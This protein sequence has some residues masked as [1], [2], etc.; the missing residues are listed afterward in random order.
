MPISFLVVHNVAPELTRPTNFLVA[1]ALFLFAEELVNL[2]HHV[3]VSVV[4]G[5][6]PVWKQYLA[7]RSCYYPAVLS[8]LLVLNFNFHIEHH[9]FPSMPWHRLRSARDILRSALGA[10]YQEAIGI[11]WNIA[12]RTRDI[13]S[14]VDRYR[15]AD[16]S[17]ALST[18]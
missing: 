7:T 15:I 11:R 6:L 4:T 10:R 1:I 18:R 3:D 16:R 14:I 8:E 2:P 17:D 12:N 5:K 9:L 13:Q